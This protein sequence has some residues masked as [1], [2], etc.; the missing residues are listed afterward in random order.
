MDVKG[1]YA[2]PTLWDV[3]WV[4]LIICPY[5]ILSFIVWHAQWFWRYTVMKQPY[6]REQKLHLIRRHLGMGQHQFEAQEDKLIEE[7]LHLELWKRDNFDAWKAEQDEEMKKKL[8][9]NPR[10]KAYR[11]YMKNHGPGRITFED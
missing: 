3:L 11:R 5:T 10:Y 9:E 8:A 4:Q 2:K 1:G 6:G 7:Y